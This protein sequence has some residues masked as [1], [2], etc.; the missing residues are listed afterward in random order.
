MR[1]G[2]DNLI[3]TLVIGDESH[4]IVVSNLT[5]LL[6]TLLDQVGL[7]LR[8]DDIVEV[9]R[10]TGQ[11][12]HAVTEVLNTIE[13][14]TSLCETYVLDNIGNDITQTLLRD[15][16]VNEAYLLRNDAIHNDT[17]YR[18]FNHVAYGLAINDVVD[19]HLHLGVEIALTLIMGNDSLLG[20]IESKALTLGLG[21]D[22]GDIIETKHHIL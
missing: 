16:L 1:P 18:S 9:E 19:H 20:T 22:L 6:I 21:T 2:I 14:L 8:D 13:E 5:N 17:T 12:C 15:D 3:V 10:Q 7:L 4:V 11:I